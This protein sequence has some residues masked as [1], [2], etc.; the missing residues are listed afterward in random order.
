MF[1]MFYEVYHI[2]FSVFP[3]FIL[4]VLQILLHFQNCM[5]NILNKQNNQQFSAKAMFQKKI[6]IHVKL[7]VT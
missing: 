7:G 2:R 6:P 3:F 5:S 4:Q 1:Y